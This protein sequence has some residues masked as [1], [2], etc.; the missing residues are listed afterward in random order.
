MAHR[1]GLA[2]QYGKNK[3][4]KLLDRQL[5]VYLWLLIAGTFI[6]GFAAARMWYGAIGWPIAIG[7]LIAGSMFF[8]VIVG[9]RR[10]SDRMAKDRIKHLR[11]GQ[12]EAL[13]AWLLQDLDDN[14]HIFN[15]IHLEKDWDIDHVLIGPAG[16]F[17]IS[18]KSHRGI[19]TGTPDGVLYNGNPCD[20]AN[21]AMWQTMALKDRLAAILGDDVPF[22][23]PVLAVPF[24]FTEGN[25]CGGKVWLV[26]QDDILN[27]LAPDGAPKRLSRA[28]IE[29]IAKAVD[30]LQS[31]AADI[32]QRPAPAP[33][34]SV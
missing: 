23:Q 4:A 7:L 28:Q 6:I 31:T 12:G 14:W 17:C 22:L 34:S 9:F 30:M 32:Y 15:R 2:G 27:C 25:A 33:S 21:K 29:R 16:V 13:V 24:G 19:F 5:S 11:G 8:A 3:A 18:T 10:F 1:H 26:H 20:F